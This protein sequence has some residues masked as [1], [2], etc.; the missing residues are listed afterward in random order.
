[1]LG[2]GNSLISVADSLRLSVASRPY[3]SGIGYLW[4]PPQK[5]WTDVLPRLTDSLACFKGLL[6]GDAAEETRLDGPLRGRHEMQRH[7]H[8]GGDLVRDRK[9]HCCPCGS[10]SPPG[11]AF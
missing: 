6:L 10:F 9:S 3:H 11:A 4:D 8:L 2:Y 5:T 7:E 1:M